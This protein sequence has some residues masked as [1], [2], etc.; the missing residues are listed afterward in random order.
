MIYFVRHGETDNN[1]EGII[2]GQLDIPLNEN[3][4]Q[5]A[6]EIKNKLK[7]LD[8]DIIFSSPLL[9]AKQTTE[10]INDSLN[11]NVIYDER[12]KEFFAGNMQG[13][14]IKDWSEK[15]KEQFKLYPENYGAES[16]LEF[17]NRCVNVFNEIPKDKNVLI[18]SHGGVYRNLYRYVNN[19]S[20]LTYPVNLP[21]NCSISTFEI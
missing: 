1:L 15:E 9:R 2:Q 19:I 20:D 4:I 12:L 3:G 6:I 11:A 7:D 13:T 14:K 18:V 8:I 5:Q 21:E 10:I 16:N 17:Y